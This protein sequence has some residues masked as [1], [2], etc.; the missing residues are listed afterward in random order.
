[1]PTIKEI[2]KACNVSV[3][4][5]SNIINHKGSVGDATRERVEQVIRE[6]N[7]TPNYVCPLE[8]GVQVIAEPFFV[9]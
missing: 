8:F 5:V 7:Y 3:A 9:F 1:M 4:T 6:M 2:A